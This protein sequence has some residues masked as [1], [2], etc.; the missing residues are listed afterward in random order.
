[1]TVKNESRLTAVNIYIIPSAHDCCWSRDLLEGYDIRPGAAPVINFDDG[2]KACDI[3]IRVVSAEAREWN[4][5]TV[6]VCSREII[7]LRNEVPHPSEDRNDRWVKVENQSNRTARRIFIKPSVVRNGVERPW[8]R[9]LLGTETIGRKESLGVHLHD[10]SHECVFDI[11]VQMEAGKKS[12]FVAF[13]KYNVCE[14]P[15]L[16]LK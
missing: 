9:N 1:M 2:K 13:N 15:I 7:T 4:F 11:K 3:D 6:N 16:K 8:S 10:G 14:G 12:N 5:Y